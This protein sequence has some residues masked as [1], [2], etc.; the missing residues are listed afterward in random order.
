MSLWKDTGVSV[1]V[2]NKWALKRRG[3]EEKGEEEEKEGE[4]EKRR[5]RKEVKED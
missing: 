5:N 1:L 4:M 3:E 2:S